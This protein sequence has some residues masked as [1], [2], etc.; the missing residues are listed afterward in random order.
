[1]N[2]AIINGVLDAAGVFVAPLL[3]NYRGLYYEELRTLFLLPQCACGL[4]LSARTYF[5]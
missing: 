2:L 1:M 4:F 3:A 5:G